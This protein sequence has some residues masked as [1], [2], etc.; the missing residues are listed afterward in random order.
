MQSARNWMLKQAQRRRGQSLDAAL[1]AGAGFGYVASR[2]KLPILRALLRTGLHGAELW[3]LSEAMPYEFLIPLFAMRATPS[4][5]SGLHWGALEGLRERVRRDAHGSRTSR[6]EV[7]IEAWLSLSTFASVLLM[8]S[9]GWIVF[10]QDSGELGPT[11][12]YGAFALVVATSAALE[13]FARTFHSGIF[14]LGRVY[15]PA[16]SVLLPEVTELLCLLG[17]WKYL[18]PFSLHLGVLL[19]ALLKLGLGLWYGARAYRSRG[20]KVPRPVRLRAL[21]HFGV[22]DLKSGSLGALASLPLQLD[23][24]L[25]L[26]LLG[27]SPADETQIPLSAPYYALRPVAGLAQ[28]WARV[29]YA[30]LVRLNHSGAGMLRER[31][32]RLLLR[33]AVVMALVSCALL[34]IG[35]TLLFDR[36][37]LDTALWFL[38]LGLVRGLFAVQQLRAFVFASHTRSIAVGASVALGLFACT[39]WD[40]TDRLTLLL[41]TALL[42][43]SLIGFRGVKSKRPELYLDQARKVSIAAWLARVVRDPRALRLCVGH[44]DGSI[45]QPGSAAIALAKAL[46]DGQVARLGRTTLLWWEAKDA[47]LTPLALAK[48][49]GCALSDMRHVEAASGREAL[50]RALE[51]RMFPQELSRA[52]EEKP[53]G[54]PMVR[55]VAIQASTLPDAMSITLRKYDPRLKGLGSRDLTRIR[56]AIM[57][58]AREQKHIPRWARFQAATYAPAGETRLAFVWT[59]EQRGAAALRRA[60]LHESWR[61]SVAM[62][63]K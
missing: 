52:L 61:A 60:V 17:L 11:G 48:A 28:A 10:R 54:D 38:P 7:A 57:A 15:R 18:G 12:L 55:L 13:L 26:A 41:L 9:V 35:S 19:T 20:M 45:C 22:P 44:V 30:D 37:G 3:L 63:P 4:L 31:F 39:F 42:M 49:T 36:Q 47:A 51:A 25:L 53:E 32:E 1:L 16:F 27:T 5:L 6:A 43:L 62:P 14:A 46:T 34:A 21:R 56:R 2:L 59:G 33:A 50:A 24:L 23:R 29:F 40:L 58:G 8:A